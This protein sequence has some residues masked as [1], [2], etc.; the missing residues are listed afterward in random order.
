MFSSSGT[1][2]AAVSARKHSASFG[3]RPS[4]A[5]AVCVALLV[6]QP[7]VFF[8][9]VLVNP[10]A[11]IPFDIEGF[12]L[13][14]ISYLGQCLRRGTAPLWDPYVYCGVPIHA[15]L[16]AQLFYPFTWLAILAGNHSHGRNLFYWVQALVPLH[17]V[18]A[19][20]FTY[21]LLRRMQLGRTASLFGASAFQLGG[22]F[23]SQAQHLGAISSAPWLPLAI[24]A[25][26]ELRHRIRVRWVAILSLAIAMSILAGFAATALIVGGSVLLF[27][28][29][30]LIARDAGWRI[31]P[32]TAAGFLG[33]AVIAA[34]QLV[35]TWQLSQASIAGLRTG[36]GTGGGMTAH[37]LVSLVLPN[38]YHIFELGTSYK[39]PYNFTYLYVYCGFATS[40]LLVLAPFLR[41]SRARM[42]FALTVASA[43]WMLGG[44]TPVYRGI[45]LLLPKLLRGALY[46]E[47]ALLAF[48]CF[49]AITAAVALERIGKRVPRIILWAIVLGTTF[50]LIQTGRDRPMNTYTGGYKTEDSEEA[51][52]GNTRML[53]DTLRRLANQTVPPSRVDY[54]DAGFAQGIRGADMLGIPTANGDNPFLLRRM[55]YYRRLFTS[56]HPWDRQLSVNRPGSPLL[57]LLN[58]AWIVGASP[59]PPGEV[60]QTGL[61]ALEPANGY[62]I[63]RNPNVVPRFF[64]VPRVRRSSSEGETFR[65]LA[66]GSFHPRDEAIVEGIA[67]DRSGLAIAD[68]SVSLY[69]P[70]RIQLTVNS[71][72]PAF[73]VTS[74][75]MYEGWEARVN[76][77]HEKLVMTNGAFRGLFLPAGSSRIVMEYHP[78]YFAWLLLLSTAAF[79]GTLAAAA[80]AHGLAYLVRLPRVVAGT[81]AREW[82]PSFAGRVHGF[83]NTEV[84][85]RQALVRSLALL[86]AVTV[87]FYWKIILT[88]QFSL[89]T[90]SEAV[91]QGYS[92]LQYWTSALRHGFLPLW[93]PY[94]IGGHIF[95][96]EMQTAA[97][98]PPHLLL[99]LF[100]PGN[101]GFSLHLYHLWYVF[102]HFLGACFLFALVREF[103]L[104]RFAAAIAG[105][106]FSLGGFVVRMAWPHML[107]SSIWLPLVFLFYLR[108]IRAERSRLAVWNYALAGL[109]LGLSILAGGLH[110][111]IFQVLAIVSA[112]T[113]NALTE[114][115]NPPATPWFRRP[116][117]R[118][119]AAAAGVMGAVALAAGAVQLLPSV[120]F[121]SR[122]VRFLG[123][124]G[125]LP[126]SEKIPYADLNEG[127]WPHSFIAMLIPEAFG[128]NMGSGEVDSPYLGV[129]P[130]MLAIYGVRKSWSHRWVR[131]FT[132]LAVAAF[133]YSFA[134]LSPLHGV[135]Y[136]VIPG[137]WMAREAGRAV[138]LADFSVAVLAAFGL[139]TLLS[140]QATPRLHRIL[141]IIAIVCAGCF[142]VPAVFGT[143]G[144][145]PWVGL[146]L[147]MILL[148]CGLFHYVAR[149]NT[150]S[151][152]R[153]LI[154]ALIVFDLGAFDWTAHNTIE[155]SRTGVNY[156][157]RLLSC[158]GAVQFL[159]SLP[160]PF[161]VEV[162]AEP[163]PNIGDF[164][165]IQTTHGGGVTAPVEFLKLGGKS[166]LL[167]V[168][169]RIAPASV[170]EPGAIYWDGAWKVYENPGA[171][172]RAWVVHETTVEASL[173][174]A[175]AALEKPGFDAWRTAVIDRPATLEPRVEGA[176]ENANI[177]AIEPNRLELSVHAASRGMLVLSEM[178]YPGWHAM[179]NSHPAAIYRTDVGLR[180]ILVP[181][182]DSRVVLNY[183][184]RSIYLGGLI[185]LITFGG[186]LAVYRFKLSGKR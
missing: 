121:S 142:L 1:G 53:A 43:F 176:D 88:N 124:F 119:A 52:A 109:M 27:A 36:D 174:G 177:S 117:C 128:G 34:V 116:S 144:M 28:G 47:Y 56:G 84:A 149:G 98:Y 60:N 132:C 152:A 61:Q 106:C 25:A 59:I 129:F 14:L 111:V 113:Y 22:F 112:A 155:V 95:A 131:Y 148:S 79:L 133:L 96:G 137:L 171:M 94:T 24:L 139:E 29:A 35:P 71:G 16:Q 23:A 122:S 173:D 156:R 32:A 92:W 8:W 45:Y 21:A 30:S 80:G 105:I 150:G 44:H 6:L 182:G 48:C 75:P 65:M 170:Q 40:I 172:P 141:T 66:Q 157:D 104:S 154:V 115:S 89:V 12:H 180:G 130:L 49:A 2:T 159:K 3:H 179:V 185:S 51:P 163:R 77:Q 55:L 63:Y 161:R 54:T 83:W 134:A 183:T 103:G 69:S 147:L 162:A 19:G 18:L 138:Y 70:N 126:A 74:E 153:V 50:D 140:S 9:R 175:L 42:F 39:L 5:G 86:L 90:E 166:H 76:G 168:R 145:S 81:A 120:E 125:S 181:A 17:M 102:V 33:G 151:W 108:A 7:V 13:P 167:N 91:N 31:I 165:G 72:A 146:S 68:V 78:P 184:P 97:F 87:V 85:P 127:P 100:P 57:S 169:Y 123:K 11:H 37:S 10:T 107:E 114:D 164:F 20:L 186:V 82:L 4:G 38:Y 99:A 26:F 160:G 178:Y 143:P 41:K 46:A 62:P 15:D 118:R 110:V 158:R 64:L 67:S 73:L 135:L 58:V 101:P 136:A 93:D